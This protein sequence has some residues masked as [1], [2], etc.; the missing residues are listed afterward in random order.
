MIFLPLPV[1]LALMLIVV[2]LMTRERLL[3]SPSGRLFGVLLLLYC[4]GLVVIGLRW[5][6]NF[7]LLLPVMAVQAALWCPLA[8]VAFRSLSREA[9]LWR[10]RDDWPHAIPAASIVVCIALYPYVIDLILLM[11]Y[12][13]YGA[14]LWRLSRRGPDALHLVRLG[15]ARL[16]HLAL[17]VTAGLLFF[18][19]FI[20]ILIS[21]EFRFNEGRRAASIVAWG[22]V[23][24]IL[25]LGLAA[26]VGGQSRPEEGESDQGPETSEIETE[27]EQESREIMQ[28]L[29]ALL[30][31]QE[32]F[33]DTEL[34]LQRLARKCGVPARKVSRAVNSLTQQ[35]VSQWVNEQRVKA[36]CELLK[37]SD[38]NV[39]QIMHS[40]GFVTKS[41]FNR[42]FKRV[43]GTSPSG[44]RTSK[45]SA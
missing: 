28:R 26:I 8:W 31:Q 7:T 9:P 12:A 11:T 27:D 5:G 16:S 20:D 36:A 42:E 44:W 22:N 37:N 14:L 2:L 32:L 17:T 43:T 19:T 30:V 45:V 33:K 10:W 1:V 29:E 15:G 6:Y 13:T 35:N 41:N 18:Y 34:N 38:E 3:Q 23:P 40:V 39:T 24:G 4:L 25:V 21:L